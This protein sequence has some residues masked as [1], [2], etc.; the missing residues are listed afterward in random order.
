MVGGAWHLL[1]CAGCNTDYTLLAHM[2]SCGGCT[3]CCTQDQSHGLL[4]VLQDTCD[5]HCG[6]DGNTEQ[7]IELLPQLFTAVWFGTTTITCLQEL[8][9]LTEEQALDLI[10]IRRLYHTNRNDLETQRK[11]IIRQL[12]EVELQDA[13]PSDSFLS[14]SALISSVQQ[15]TEQDWATYYT[16]LRGAYRGVRHRHLAY[17]MQ[18]NASCKHLPDAINKHHQKS[19]V[20]GPSALLACCMHPCV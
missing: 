19:G 1:V 11:I 14:L 17:H 18:T 20:T 3:T 7:F 15:I 8:M 2:R 12:A 5:C 16:V 9:S 4:S 6:G 10:Y 13:H